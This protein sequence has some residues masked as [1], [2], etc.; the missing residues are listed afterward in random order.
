MKFSIH[1]YLLLGIMTG[2]SWARQTK[3]FCQVDEKV[4]FGFETRSKKVASNSTIG[5][6]R[7]K[8]IVYR[9]GTQRKV[10][11]ELPAERD[12]SFKHFEKYSFH[13]NPSM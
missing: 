2:Q 12:S 3:T 5:S 13:L 4:V 6:E 9:F 10:E 7:T 8:Y 11:M 1:L